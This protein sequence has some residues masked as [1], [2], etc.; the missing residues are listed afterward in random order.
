MEKSPPPQQMIKVIR[1]EKL[2]V[3][4]ANKEEIKPAAVYDCNQNVRAIDFKTECY[5]LICL[6][7]KGCQV[8]NVIIQMVINIASC[9]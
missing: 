6:N 2:K 8:V 5:S 4:K 1:S 7:K 3:T 9:S